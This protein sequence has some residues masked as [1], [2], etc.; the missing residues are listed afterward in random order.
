MKGYVIDKRG[1]NEATFRSALR[2]GQDSSGTIYGAIKSRAGENGDYIFKGLIDGPVIEA[3][4]V[5]MG[6]GDDFQLFAGL[7]TRGT[8]AV[9]KGVIVDCQ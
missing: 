3:D 6:D 9:M 1:R 4:V 8:R 5:S 7:T 2:F